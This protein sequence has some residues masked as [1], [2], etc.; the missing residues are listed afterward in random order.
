MSEN[1]VYYIVRF[2]WQLA[3]IGTCTYIVFWMG[4]TGWWYLLAFLICGVGSSDNNEK[5][6]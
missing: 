4:H 5:T 1:S 6:S 2:L 3:V